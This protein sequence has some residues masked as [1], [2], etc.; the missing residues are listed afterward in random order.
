[1]RTGKAGHVA[2][3]G[4]CRVISA[5]RGGSA[6]MGMFG[7]ADRRHQAAA[8]KPAVADQSASAGMIRSLLPEATSVP[9]M[10]WTAA[11]KTSPEI[12]LKKFCE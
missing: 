5:A 2:L 6:A 8:G 7:G 11:G 10:D 1:M 9:Q 12:F 4:R 3:Q